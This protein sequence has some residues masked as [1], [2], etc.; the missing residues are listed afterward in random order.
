MDAPAPFRDR[1]LVFL[2]ELEKRDV[3]YLVVGLAAAALQGAPAATVDVD[4]W[5]DDLSSPALRDALAAVGATYVAPTAS[6]PPLLAGEAVS[7][8]DVVVHMHGLGTF[9]EEFAGAVRVDVGGVVVPL[10]P[11]ERIITS[12]RTTRRPKDLA[13]LPALEAAL[14]ARGD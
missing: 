9:D 8:F 3:R 7:L 14:R 10:L 6:N 4:L 5:F 13:I 11:L 12:K 2:G 1:E